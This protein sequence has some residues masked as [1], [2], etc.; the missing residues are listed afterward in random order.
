MAELTQNWYNVEWFEPQLVKLKVL[1]LNS[2]SI[3]WIIFSPFKQ[4]IHSQHRMK[5]VLILVYVALS[6][7]ALGHKIIHNSF[8][9]APWLIRYTLIR[10]Y[11]SNASERCSE[12]HEGSSL[13]LCKINMFRWLFLSMRSIETW[14]HGRIRLPQ[15]IGL[16]WETLHT[17]L[18][19]CH[20][21]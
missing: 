4:A 21:K 16:R 5:N 14:I 15:T 19:H 9:D 11:V 7:E 6:E 10:S 12:Q 17:S 8:H 1:K 20:F 18:I 13:R 2:F 3:F